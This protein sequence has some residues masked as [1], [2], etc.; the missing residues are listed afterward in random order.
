M[1][2]ASS[3]IAAALVVFGRW[4]WVLLVV[5]ALLLRGI[6]PAIVT[7]V[8]VRPNEISIERPYIQRHIQA[9]RAAF[10]IDTHTLAVM[11]TAGNGEI[12]VSPLQ[13]S[14]AATARTPGP[15]KACR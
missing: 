6:I 10:A 4:R 3:V 14:P 2:I 9:T 7:G 8:Y 15:K 13:P 11:T 1:T 12:T 5:A